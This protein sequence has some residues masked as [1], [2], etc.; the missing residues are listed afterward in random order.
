M[1]F[2]LVTPEKLLFSGEATYVSAPGS[3][4][5]FGVLSGHMPLISTLKSDAETWI[6]TDEGVKKFKIQGGFAEVTPES[7]VILAENAEE[8]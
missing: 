7:V 8:L 3:E 6:E 2:E 4:G 1:R 5:D